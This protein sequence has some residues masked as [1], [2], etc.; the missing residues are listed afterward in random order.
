[1]KQQTL[2]FGVGKR[3]SLAKE[4]ESIPA[5][6]ATAEPSAKREEKE[7]SKTKAASSSK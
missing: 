4:A 5:V 2:S 1:M 6:E 7:K 3:I